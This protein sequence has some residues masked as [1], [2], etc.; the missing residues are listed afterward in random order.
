MMVECAVRTPRQHGD[1]KGIV[2]GWRR[3]ESDVWGGLGC[4][5]EGEH[6]EFQRSETVQRGP[7]FYI[8]KAI[9]SIGLMV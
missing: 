2:W 8:L 7:E 9:G 6:W 5:F 3:V 1:T 4:F